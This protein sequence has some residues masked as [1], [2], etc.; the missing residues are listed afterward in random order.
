MKGETEFNGL[1]VS[2][3]LKELDADQEKYVAELIKKN[4]SLQQQCVELE[5]LLGLIAIENKVNEI[6]IN[7]ERLVFE[8]MKSKVNLNADSETT[9]SDED[10][11]HDTVHANRPRKFWIA[12]ASVMLLIA[13]GS[14]FFRS[15][16]GKS[17]ELQQNDVA[18]TPSAI[19]IRHESN[20]S[21]KVKTILLEDGTIV[22]L[23]DKTEIEFP[24]NFSNNKRDIHLNGKASFKVA[25]DK[26]RPFTV[27]STHISTTA[28]GTEF[29]VTNYQ[30]DNAIRVHLIEGSVVVKSVDSNSTH[31]ATPYYLSPGQ[32]LVYDKRNATVQ[33]NI[34][35]ANSLPKP[36]KDIRYNDNPSMPSDKEGSWFMFNNQSLPE[37]FDQLSKMYDVNIK[38]RTN[39]LEKLY[40]IGKFDKKDSLEYILRNIATMNK[41]NVSKDGDGYSLRKKL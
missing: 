17:L 21:G 20:V 9:F 31:F 40:F 5:N 13:A 36:R 35:K 3:L 22:T 25:K 4:Q 23:F 39:E 24:Q 10:F 16:S 2:Y 30:E 41:L 33:I 32:E 7:K 6:D 8:K 12:A 19:N 18:V 28:L 27:Y 38:Y 29:V 26:T 15:N 14:L 11:N 34:P 1:L 37:V